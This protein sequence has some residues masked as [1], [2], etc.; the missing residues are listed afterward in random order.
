MLTTTRTYLLLSGLVLSSLALAP[1]ARAA[2]AAPVV[3]LLAGAWK[4]QELKIPATSDLDRE[5]WGPNASKV[6]NIQLAIEPDGS[7]TLRIQSSV[8]DAAGRPK[9]YSQSVIEARL[10]VG[11]PQAGGDRVQ[12]AVTVVSAEERYL[13]DPKDVRR[14]EGLRLKLD[15]M[16]RES[17]DLNIFYE[18]AEGNGSFGETLRRQV[19]TRKS[20][21]LAS[22]GPRRQT[23]G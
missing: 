4:A 13:D 8:V 7:G 21:A 3:P 18:T 15:L 6:R 19:Q 10:K 9:R 17:K 16:N 22:A 12:P 1:S 2:Q 5:V 23:Q 11:E 14:I 20:A